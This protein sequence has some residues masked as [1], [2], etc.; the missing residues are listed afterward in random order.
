VR[1][2]AAGL[3]ALPILR[4]KTDDFL[5][6]AAQ[7]RLRLVATSA[8]G[9]VPY[10]QFDWRARPLALCIGSEGEGLPAAVAAACREQVS[11]PMKGQAE[12]LNAAVAASILLFE[13][14]G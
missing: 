6:A 12:S 3:L 4:F 7:E 2:T 1:A 8:H 11:I 10:G 9:G 5:R 13:A 14:Q